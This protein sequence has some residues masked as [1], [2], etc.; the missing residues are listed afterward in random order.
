MLVL[1]TNKTPLLDH[2]PKRYL[3]IDD[4][5]LSDTLTFPENWRVNYFDPSKH[6]LNP[7]HRLT[8]EKAEAFVSLIDAAFPG[9][10]NTLTKQ[11]S[12]IA[13]LEALLEKPRTIDR[14]VFNEKDPDQKAAAQKIKRIV[15]SPTLRHVLTNPTNFTMTGIVLARL[16]GS[17]FDRFILGNLLASRYRGTVVIPTF[18]FYANKSHSQLIEEGRLIAGLNTLSELDRL[19]E[20][21]NLLLLGEKIGSHTTYDDACTIAD[22][23]SV[24]RH[25]NGYTDF[26]DGCMR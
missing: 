20:L 22:Y 2:L 3:L 17:R 6:T 1:G 4:G 13:L 9:G 5:T 18:G 12:A 15:L 8:Y 10:E 23:T 25:T 19:P 7:L 21:R 26:I 16:T 14:L 24:P 11:N